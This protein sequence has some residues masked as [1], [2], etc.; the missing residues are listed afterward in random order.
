MACVAP[1]VLSSP[2]L[3]GRR[4]KEAARETRLDEITVLVTSAEAINTHEVGL[5]YLSPWQPRLPSGVDS[6][7]GAQGDGCWRIHVRMY[8]HV[9]DCVRTCG[10]CE[11]SHQHAREGGAQA[12]MS[13]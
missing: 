3:E 4:E 9:C 6:E 7:G 5:Q 2:I 1:R 12:R 11:C 8:A 10:C 13:R